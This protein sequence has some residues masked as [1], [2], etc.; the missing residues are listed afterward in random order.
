[1]SNLGAY[2][3]MTTFAKKVGGP[4]Q[5]SILVAVCGYVIIRTG[6]TGVKAIIKG[7]QKKNYNT[8]IQELKTYIVK[9]EGESNEGLKFKVGDR[10]RVMEVVE[11][12]ILIEKLGDENN[13][14]FVSYDLLKEISDYKKE[15]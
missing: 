12:V 11:D 15:E 9:S 4:K 6:E 10:F 3:T 1:M 8:A 13:P 2:Q 14:Y 7:I 5:L